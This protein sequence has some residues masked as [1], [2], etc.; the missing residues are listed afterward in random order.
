[1]MQWT[2]EKTIKCLSS[3]DLDLSSSL[4]CAISLKCEN[5]QRGRD[6]GGG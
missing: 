5:D 3:E 2:V 1:M 6:G 4:N